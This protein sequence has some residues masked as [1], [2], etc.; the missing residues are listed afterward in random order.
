VKDITTAT[1]KLTGIQ[2]K[3]MNDSQDDHEHEEAVDPDPG[4]I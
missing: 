1:E 3:Q 4:P 2:Y